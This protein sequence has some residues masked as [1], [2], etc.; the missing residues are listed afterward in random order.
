MSSK[1][2]ASKRTLGT[3]L[4]YVQRHGS[5]FR[6]WYMEN[7]RQRRGPTFPTQDQAHR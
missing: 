6:G 1:K 5:G 2:R 7:G 4:A 3:R